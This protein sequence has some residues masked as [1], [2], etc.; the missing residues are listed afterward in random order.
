MAQSESGAETQSAAITGDSGFGVVAR[1]INKEGGQYVADTTIYHDRQKFREEVSKSWWTTLASQQTD[2]VDYSDKDVELVAVEI[3]G[4]FVDDDDQ[5]SNPRT[6]YG[7]VGYNGPETTLATIPLYENADMGNFGANDPPVEQWGHDP[8]FAGSQAAYRFDRVRNKNGDWVN[9]SYNS[10]THPKAAGITIYYGVGEPS[11]VDTEPLRNPDGLPEDEDGR[12]DYSE[13]WSFDRALAAARQRVEDQQAV[14]R[15]A[16]ADHTLDATRFEDLEEQFGEEAVAAAVRGTMAGEET[17]KDIADV[18]EVDGLTDDAL[19]STAT[20][21][22][23]AMFSIADD[24]EALAEALGVT[25][26]DSD[27]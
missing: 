26:G 21:T 13:E 3:Q 27:E 25:G 12:P 10:V 2:A 1:E 20:E 15:R 7:R 5:W 8:V 4:W 14:E 18:E 23:Y 22:V 24:E 19:A 9:G 6:G 16:D 11:A 17:F